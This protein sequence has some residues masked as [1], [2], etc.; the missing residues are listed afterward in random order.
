MEPELCGARERVGRWIGL[1]GTHGPG[2]LGCRGTRF[3]VL[4]EESVIEGAVTDTED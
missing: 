3:E 4:I 1:V 2:W